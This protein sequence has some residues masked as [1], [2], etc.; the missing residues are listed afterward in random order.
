MNKNKTARPAKNSRRSSSRPARR[1]QRRNRSNRVINTRNLAI[2]L[3]FTL[4]A[5]LVYV[6]WLDYRLLDRF[7][8]RMWTLPARVYAR[9]LEIFEGKQISTE[10]LLSEL[11]NLNYSHTDEPP[12]QAG[13][14]HHWNNHFEIRTRN[15]RFWDGDEKSR[16]F[17]LDITAGVVTGLYDLYTRKPETLSRFDPA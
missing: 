14:Y 13:S 10:Q 1:K 17:R 15:F 6:S 11:E 12:T 9:P 5:S 7:S 16:G 8:G 3:L 4:V 2:L